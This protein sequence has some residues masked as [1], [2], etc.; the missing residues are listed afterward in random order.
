M[1]SNK[2]EFSLPT[3]WLSVV[4]GIT[5]PSAS[6]RRDFRSSVFQILSADY[7]SSLSD[8]LGSCD[9]VTHSCNTGVHLAAC[10]NSSSSSGTAAQKPTY[11][12]SS[13]FRPAVSVAS[14]AC[15]FSDAVVW[16]TSFTDVTRFPFFVVSSPNHF[17]ARALN[18]QNVR[19]GS[20]RLS[21]RR[22]RR[23]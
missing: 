6:C 12:V 9:Q 13:R 2:P 3:T 17:A 15:L 21:L 14:P 10:S 19:S 4:E 22:S 8:N 16:P 5:F 23:K 1:P 20:S 11:Q 7:L 18:D